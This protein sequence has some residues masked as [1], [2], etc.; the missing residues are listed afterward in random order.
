MHAI[1]NF[2]RL[3]RVMWQYRENTS[4]ARWWV[5]G[6]FHKFSHNQNKRPPYA[7]KPFTII[8]PPR[9]ENNLSKDVKRLKENGGSRLPN[10][11]EGR[12][13][14]RE[15]R[16]VLSGNRGHAHGA[17]CKAPLFITSDPPSGLTPFEL[18]SAW[19]SRRR[20]GGGSRC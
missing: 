5:Q 13:G 1:L 16:I 11:G 10:Q 19:R 14:G 2:S 3:S 18:R 15:A 20:R 17:L 6:G 4:G 12:Q 8:N 9:V 7:G